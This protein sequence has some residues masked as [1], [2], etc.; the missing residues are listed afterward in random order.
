MLAGRA[1][2]WGKGL[3]LLVIGLVLA[4]AVAL[5]WVPIHFGSDSGNE[6]GDVQAA[7]NAVTQLA[8]ASTGVGVRADEAAYVDSSSS[9]PPS[10]ST[11]EGTSGGDRV[12]KRQPNN[13]YYGK[14][15]APQCTANVTVGIVGECQYLEVPVGAELILK[16]DSPGDAAALQASG[17]DDWTN[18]NYVPIQPMTRSN[19]PLN[20]SYTAAGSITPVDVTKVSGDEVRFK[21][22][23]VQGYVLIKTP[24][25]GGQAPRGSRDWPKHFCV[26]FGS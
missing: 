6:I 16:F 23:N 2:N 22:P 24:F 7:E 12:R 21:C 10:S 19:N 11:S 4:L 14:T 1:P 5:G 20:L 8:D 17:Y 9:P 13:L 18:C 3:L 26:K 15:E 25:H